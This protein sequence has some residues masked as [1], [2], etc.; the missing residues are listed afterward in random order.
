M[1]TTLKDKMQALDVKRRKKV[2]ARATE[3]IAEEM[4][5]RDLRKAMVKSVPLGRMIEAAEIA[6]LAVFLASSDA[7]G[8]T[9]QAISISGGKLM[10]LEYQLLSAQGCVMGCWLRGG[11]KAA[12]A[13]RKFFHPVSHPLRCVDNFGASF[14]NGDLN[15]LVDEVCPS[16]GA[17]SRSL[18][19]KWDGRWRRGNRV[20]AST[21]KQ[22]REASNPEEVQWK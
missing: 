6:N 21:M 11:C 8:I 12:P 3:L 13:R 5:L 14:E 9:D 1:A 7:D 19:G 20:R 2:E 17:A 15:I 10:F 16:T 22:R 18:A 4:S